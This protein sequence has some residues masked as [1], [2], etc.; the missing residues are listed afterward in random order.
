ML[1]SFINSPMVCGLLGS[2][3]TYA[4]VTVFILFLFSSKYELIQFPKYLRLRR[5]TLRH[6]C[7]ATLRAVQIPHDRI[8]IPRKIHLPCIQ[9]IVGCCRRQLVPF[10]VLLIFFNSSKEQAKGG[11]VY[12]NQF[13]KFAAFIFSGQP[14]CD[15]LTKVHSLSSPT[16]PSLI[17]YLIMVSPDLDNMSTNTPTLLS[18]HTL[19]ADLLINPF[20]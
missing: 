9:A 16:K 4:L 1:N 8:H 14:A 20:F 13:P 7:F 3:R 18:F 12:L 2:A 19:G 17:Y 11:Y 6:A 10:S 15:L 5:N